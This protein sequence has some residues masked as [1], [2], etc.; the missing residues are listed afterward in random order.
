M[1]IYSQKTWAEVVGA[2]GCRLVEE[3]LADVV[4][5]Y[6]QSTSADNH[7]GINKKNADSDSEFGCFDPLKKCGSVRFPDPR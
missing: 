1:R 6:K 3:Y 4:N 7:A 2:E 5:Y